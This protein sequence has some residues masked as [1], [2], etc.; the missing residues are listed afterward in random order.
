MDTYI[1]VY[2]YRDMNRQITWYDIFESEE[3]SVILV[4]AS[5]SRSIL[6]IQIPSIIKQASKQTTYPSSQLPQELA[7]LIDLSIHHITSALLPER[8]EAKKK[9]YNLIIS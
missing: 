8:H 1:H 2:I 3:K 9:N 6:L 5:Q 4:S 7:V